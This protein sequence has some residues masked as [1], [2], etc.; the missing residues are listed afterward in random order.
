MINQKRVIQTFLNLVQINS[1]TGEEKEVGDFVLQTMRGM[2]IKA[3]RDKIG[4]IIIRLEGHGEPLF[5]NAHLDTVQPGGEI[6]PKIENGIIKSDGSTILG[7]DNK[8]TIAAF[9][10]VLRFLKEGKTR[11]LE[12]VLT[13]SEESK[14]L[15]AINLDYSSL[16]AKRGFCFDCGEDLGSIILSSPFYDRFDILIKGKPSHAA[17]PERG[18]NALEIAS[19][20]INELDFGRIDDFTVSNIGIIF[21]G[22][23]RNVI[24][25]EINL[26]GEARSFKKENLENYEKEILNFFKKAEL[27]YKFKTEIDF[28]RENAG[29]CFNKKDEDVKKI[30]KILKKKSLEI[31]YK[32][33]WACSDANIFN[34]KGIKVF[35]LGDG[36]ENIHSHQESIKIED[37][38]NLTGL[39]IEI[40]KG[41]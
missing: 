20:M 28:V 22:S 27:S 6:N 17:F 3:E 16:K 19:W 31:K 33:S 41:F 23:A 13:V 29:Y 21:G 1:P 8:S 9:I 38:I 5:L 34:E 12:I 30:K 32:K 2:K 7:A 18:V 24:P 4:N 39:I 35:N 14:N 10:E 40:I 37:L 26:S 36:V 25:G 15:G 11:P